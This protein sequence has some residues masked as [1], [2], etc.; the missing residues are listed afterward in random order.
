MP[1][2]SYT[3]LT[4]KDWD[5][6]IIQT[7]M[8]ASP[9]CLC[10][11]KCRVNR[12][13][14]QKGFCRAPGNMVVSGT[15][16][17]FGE[18]PPV[19]GTKG[20]GTIFFSYCT[21]K[22]LFCQNFQISHEAAGNPYSPAALASKM[23]DLQ[24]QG[25]HNINLVTASHFLPWLLRAIREAAAKG[26]YIPIVYNNGGYESVETLKLLYGIVDIYLPDMKYGCPGY[27]AQY[28][29]APDYIDINRAAVK[30]MFRQVG[31]LKTDGNGIVK[32][33][34]CI[35]HLV[36]PNGRAC[37]ENVL[38]FL[39]SSFDPQ[40]LTISLMAQYRPMYRAKEFPELDSV[41]D[42]GE[43]EKTR[44]LFESAEIGGFYQQVEK[45]NEKFC[46]DFSKRTTEPLKE[47]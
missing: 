29:N 31:P 46:I 40:D 22:C 28:S 20:S 36:L 47:D 44:N 13:A 41:I 18:E 43:Y 7:D 2:G 15:F 21:L 8:L 45:L 24:G 11:R 42:A 10:P 17:H 30:E 23:L 37:S 39:V 5:D 32:R 33:G 14:G 35:R 4:E 3:Y 6:R 16:P 26:L 12:L 38:D 25:C 27:A 19:S 34:L 1:V 9:C